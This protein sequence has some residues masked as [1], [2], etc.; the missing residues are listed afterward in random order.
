MRGLTVAVGFVGS[1]AG[2]I[3]SA[4]LPLLRVRAAPTYAA[5]EIGRQIEAGVMTGGAGRAAVRR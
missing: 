4:G 1:W 3:S 5:T 2:E